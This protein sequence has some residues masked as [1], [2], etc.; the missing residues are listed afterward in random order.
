MRQEEKLIRIYTGS[1]IN[2]L[3]LKGEL[4]N[5]EISA[6]INN[7]FQ[8]SVSAGFVMDSPS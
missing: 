4:E 2:V 8:S 6:I 7:R 3:H 5:N 1:E